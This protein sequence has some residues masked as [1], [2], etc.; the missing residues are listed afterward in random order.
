MQDEKANPVKPEPFL[1]SIPVTLLL[2]AALV[3]TFL[4]ASHH[5]AKYYTAIIDS[6]QQA[7][8]KEK[9]RKE[10]QR[11]ADL[12]PLARRY[13]DCLQFA[14]NA[15]DI[16]EALPALDEASKVVYDA[17]PNSDDAHVA[18]G[19]LFDLK[20]SLRTHKAR[21][22]TGIEQWRPELQATLNRIPT[23]E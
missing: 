23:P 16:S 3:P 21:R 5:W 18:N 11:P 4:S 14:R 7:S 12:D 9:Q 17:I 10:M 8:E 19:L 20:M 6:G 22:Q 1:F 13:L 2:A 15:T